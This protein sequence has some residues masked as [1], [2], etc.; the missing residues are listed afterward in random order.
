[1][2]TRALYWFLS[3]TTWIQS[4]KSHTISP[5]FILI[6]SSYLRLRLPSGIIFFYFPIKTLDVWGARGSVVGWGTMLQAGRS[7]VWFTMSLDF[8]VDLILP[9]ALWPWTDSASNRNEYQESSWGK[10]RP[11][12]R[13]DNL[14]A[15]CEPNVWKCGNLDLSQPYGPPRPVQG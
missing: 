2:F 5:R 1:V 7:R 3:W 4:I 14:A 11:A 8:S 10:K 15:I 12:R 6:L 13:A 9:A